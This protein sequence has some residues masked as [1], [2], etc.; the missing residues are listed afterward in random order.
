MCKESKCKRKEKRDT[1]RHV[2]CPI[3]TCDGGG[4][5]DLGTK[6]IMA[7]VI[8]GRC[9]TEG[10]VVL[11]LDVTVVDPT[12]VCSKVFPTM[13]ATAVQLFVDL[14]SERRETQYMFR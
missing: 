13:P 6:H 11:P 4:P 2:I 14:L 8:G 1:K 12:H 3:G 7:Q 5:T 9:P 10:A